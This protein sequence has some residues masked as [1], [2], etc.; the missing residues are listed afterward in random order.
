VRDALAKDA[1]ASGDKPRSAAIKA[2]RKP[3][4]VAWALNQ[5]VRQ[6]RPSVEQL[7][8]L[9]E[10]LKAAQDSLAGDALRALGRQR[11]ELVRAVAG[12]A[13]DI[14][15]GNGRPLPRTQVDLIA[16]SLDAALTNPTNAALLLA[17]RLAT[18]LE[19]VELGAPG[20]SL[21]LVPA[22]PQQRGRA[23]KPDAKEVRLA[24]AAVEAAEQEVTQAEAERVRAREILAAAHL[25]AGVTL[26]RLE[27]AREESELAKADEDVA[28]R[29]ER[30][31]TRSEEIATLRLEQARAHAAALEG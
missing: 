19:Y 14:A 28:I 25:R 31:A 26:E 1:T 22:Q 10:D 29:A 4:V 15:E 23:R 24:R 11:H 27:A 3:S 9:G 12:R 30:E 20:P 13:A 17:G 21:T 2:L 6:D 7:V 16:T 5:L 8:S 18:G